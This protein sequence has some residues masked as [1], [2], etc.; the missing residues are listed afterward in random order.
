M[1]IRI[2]SAA[3]FVSNDEEAQD[4]LTTL[5]H[6]SFFQNVQRDVH[7]NVVGFKI[8]SLLHDFATIMSNNMCVQIGQP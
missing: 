3:G 8:H 1:L 7:D 4:Y 5:V 6:K 2:R